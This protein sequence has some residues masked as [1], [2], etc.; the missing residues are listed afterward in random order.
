MNIK[1]HPYYIFID[2]VNIKNSDPNL[3]SIDK[4]SFKKTDAAICNIK[5]ITM[6]SVDNENID[7]ENPP[8]LI[9]NSIDRYIIEESNGYKYLF[10]ASTKDNQKMLRKYKKF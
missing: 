5:H 4:I 8:C 9:F 10:F 1:N 6:E 2:K 7:S 3:L